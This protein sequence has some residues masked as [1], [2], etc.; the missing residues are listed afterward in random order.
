MYVSVPPN[1]KDILAMEC[2]PLN[3]M[4]EGDGGK[5]EEVGGGSVS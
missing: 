3:F 2:Q 4:R 1:N 5:E